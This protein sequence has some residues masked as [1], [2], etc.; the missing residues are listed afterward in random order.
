MYSTK[1]CNVHSSRCTQTP[2]VVYTISL[3]TQPIHISYRLSLCT[4]PNFSVLHYFSLIPLFVYNNSMYSTFFRLCPS[5]CYVTRTRMLR[6]QHSHYFY[7]CTQRI[8]CFW[9]TMQSTTYIRQQPFINTLYVFL[10]SMFIPSAH[11]LHKIS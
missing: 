1:P 10:Y 8:T 7:H 11:V 4:R 3:C 2:A 5:I 6:I 9:C